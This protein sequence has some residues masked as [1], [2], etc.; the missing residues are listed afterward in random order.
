M[1]FLFDLDK[2]STKRWRDVAAECRQ[3]LAGTQIM[4]GD[5]GTILHDVRVML[6]AVGPEGMATQTNS[7]CVPSDRLAGL[8]PK[9][10]HPLELPLK[11]PLLRDYPNL[12]GVF[13]LLRVMGLLV[14]ERNRLVLS[15][16][17][18]GLVEAPVWC[19]FRLDGQDIQVECRRVSQAVDEQV[20]ELRRRAHPPYSKPTGTTPGYYDESNAAYLIARDKHDKI[21]RSV[22]IYEGCPAVAA[23]K[24]GWWWPNRSTTTC[25]DC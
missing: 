14:A 25:G 15:A 16:P 3:R 18:M 2:E 4:Y 19:R 6:E 10:G 24:P 8:N 12:A 5:P 1:F 9:V 17:V 7:G 22:L 23:S 11:R 21:A 13:V 20:R